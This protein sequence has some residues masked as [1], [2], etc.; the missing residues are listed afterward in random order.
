MSETQGSVQVP[1]SV[2]LFGGRHAEPASRLDVSMAVIEA[3]TD[4]GD[5]VIDLLGTDGE[6]LAAATSSGRSVVVP[7]KAGTHL[8][9]FDGMS[10]VADLVLAIPIGIG[11]GRRPCRAVHATAARLLRPGGLFVTRPLGSRPSGDPVSTTVASAAEAGLDYFQHV[12]VLN[13]S[14]GP[15]RSGHVS[16]NG[17]HIDLLTF[18]RGR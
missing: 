8:D 13:P 9:A 3:Y 14:A 18:R 1:L 11:V 17:N 12:V 10:A 15:S 5:V 7:T 6:V 4:P 2:W 16:V